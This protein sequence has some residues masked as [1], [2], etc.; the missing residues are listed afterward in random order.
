M[1]LCHIVL[2]LVQ[3]Q[4]FPCSLFHLLLE[5]DWYRFVTVSGLHLHTL[6]CTPTSWSI[7]CSYLDLKRA[8]ELDLQSLF[9]LAF[10]L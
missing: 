9:R 10:D 6:N 7:L 8:T 4:W 5:E 2:T 3:V 1:V